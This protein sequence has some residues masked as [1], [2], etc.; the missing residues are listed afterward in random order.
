[1]KI[2]MAQCII[3]SCFAGKRL[4]YNCATRLWLR[5]NAGPDF[6]GETGRT[7]RGDGAETEC[8]RRQRFQEKRKASK[9][10]GT[11][12]LGRRQ[13]LEAHRKMRLF[14]FMLSS[15]FPVRRSAAFTPS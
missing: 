3:E 7:L 14:C 13:Y 1:V 4:H 15:F 12:G 10:Q 11:S 9:M 5:R 8:T 6:E 2:A